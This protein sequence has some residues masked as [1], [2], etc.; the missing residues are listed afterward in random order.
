MKQYKGDVRKDIKVNNPALPSPSSVISFV[1]VAYNPAK[2]KSVM[3]PGKTAKDHKSGA[4]ARRV[5]NQIK[6][7]SEPKGKR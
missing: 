5:H 3:R 4:H 2:Q 1:P 6:R 7:A